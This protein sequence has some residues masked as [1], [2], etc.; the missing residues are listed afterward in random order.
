[1]YFAQEKSRKNPNPSLTKVWICQ[2]LKFHCMILAKL[3][4]RLYS[5]WANF[6]S[7]L[8]R[9]HATHCVDCSSVPNYSSVPLCLKFLCAHSSSVPTLPLWFL[10][11]PLC[12]LFLHAHCSSVPKCSS[13]HT[14]PLCLL[15]PCAYCS[16]VPS[17]PLCPLFLCAYCSSVPTVPLCLLFLCV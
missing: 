9:W 4:C 7:S 11:I 13:V 15:F 5:F 2:C 12:L 3:S 16:F 6:L 10:C 14:V 1:M 8:T 17:V